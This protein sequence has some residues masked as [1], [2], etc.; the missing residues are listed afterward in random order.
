M[1]DSLKGSV[2]VLEGLG[3]KGPCTQRAFPWVL[4]G[5]LYRYFSATVDTPNSKPESP[6]S[7]KP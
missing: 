1:K 5:F 4:K 3:F 6:E 2:R 7:P